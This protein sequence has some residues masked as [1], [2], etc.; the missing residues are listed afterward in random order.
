MVEHCPP[1]LLYIY[2]NNTTWFSAGMFAESHL[3]VHHVGLLKVVQDLWLVFHVH[4][5][6]SGEET[7]ENS[8][9]VET[10]YDL[11]LGQR[12]LVHVEHKLGLL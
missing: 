2:I 10:E 5:I 7:V 4:C 12:D 3:H 6:V 1:S 11:L 8:S 9:F